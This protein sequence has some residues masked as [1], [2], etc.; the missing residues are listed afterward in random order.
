MTTRLFADH[1]ATVDSFK[2]LSQ[3]ERDQQFRRA[4]TVG[5]SDVSKAAALISAGVS[6]DVINGI[7]RDGDRELVRRAQAS[8]ALSEASHAP[9]SERG[10]HVVRA[11]GMVLGS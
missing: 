7:S 8:A 10:Q 6:K 5:Q 9:R 3:E 11:V 2:G 4:V 1:W